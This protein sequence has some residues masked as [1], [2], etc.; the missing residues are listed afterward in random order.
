MSRPS[1]EHQPSTRPY[2][3][4]PAEEHSTCRPPTS[5]LKCAVACVPQRQ[6][7]NQPLLGGKKE[8]DLISETFLRYLA[9]KDATWPL[10]FPM[11]KSAVSAMTAL[12]DFGQKQYGVRVKQFV[13]TGGSL[14]SS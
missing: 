7:P 1:T 11:V 8:D 14:R 13:V 6:V 3:S 4:R 9:T 5:H 10:L 2:L 12:Q